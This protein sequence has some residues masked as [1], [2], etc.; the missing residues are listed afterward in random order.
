M[1]RDFFE[2]SG[3]GGHSKTTIGI[4]LSDLGRKSLGF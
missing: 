4:K 1:H 2:L 3:L